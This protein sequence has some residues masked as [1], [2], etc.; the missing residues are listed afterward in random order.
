MDR[1]ADAPAL[2]D[3]LGEYDTGYDVVEYAEAIGPALDEFSHR[4]RLVLHLRFVDD[5]T[6]TE[7]AQRIGV[8]QMHVSRILRSVLQ[9]LHDVPGAGPRPSEPSK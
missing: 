5:M 6:Q 2:L 3:S 1:D 7:I 9:R 4:D 8:S